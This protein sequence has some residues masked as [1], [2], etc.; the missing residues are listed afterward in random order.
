MVDKSILPMTEFEIKAGKLRPFYFISVVWGERYT[1]FLL[2]CCIASLMSPNNIPA[3]LNHG[4]KFLIAAP[5]D[6]WKRMQ[7]MP[8]FQ[9]LKEHIEPVWIR[10]PAP[11]NPPIEM[12]CFHMGI[13]HK[14]ALRMAFDDHAYAAVLPPDMMT[15]DGTVAAMQRHAVDGKE[16]VLSVALRF[17]EEPL[18]RHLEHIGLQFQGNPITIT[19]RQLVAACLPSMHSETTRYEWD[20]PT[21]TDFPSAIWWRVPTDGIIV[22][23]LGWIP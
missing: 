12:P 5:I 14:L 15:S 9:T 10:I 18:F 21:F 16:V 3:L 22:H 20:S 13:G 4:N 17:G 1:D 23:S 2:N 19:S 7:T 11:P 6:D 8:M